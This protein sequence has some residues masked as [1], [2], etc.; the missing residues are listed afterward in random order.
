MKKT[1]YNMT[2]YNYLYTIEVDLSKLILITNLTDLYRFSLL[3]CNN[4]SFKKDKT[5]CLDVDWRQAI[6]QTKKA[7]IL[8]SPNI[9]ELINKHKP[10]YV[11]T[12]TFSG[13]EWYVTW[14]IAS[15]VIWN[16][17]AITNFKQIYQRE[18]GEFT[19][20]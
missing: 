2:K 6:K 16:K 11:N 15:G 3:Y 1:N 14:D 10:E 19:K 5:I 13:L 4:K 20:V 8:I 17:S 9:K 18:A 7:G 12:T